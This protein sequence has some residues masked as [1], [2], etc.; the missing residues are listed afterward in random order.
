ML[1]ILLGAVL[2]TGGCATAS[3]KAGPSGADEESGAT[4]PMIDRFAP[5]I[6]LALG[7]IG[8]IIGSELRLDLFRKRGR[9][10][11]SILFSQVFVTFSVV[12][13]FVTLLTQ[14]LYIGILFGSLA[15]AT[16]PAAAVRNE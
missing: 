14:K 11:Y 7:V 8:F 13:F 16:D 3:K 2:L 6:N 5:I 10:I 12:A 1:P 9:S 4:A 15:S